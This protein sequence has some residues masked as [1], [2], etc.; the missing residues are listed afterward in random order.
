MNRLAAWALRSPFL[1]GPAHLDRCMAMVLVGLLLWIPGAQAQVLKDITTDI[2]A[3][4]KGPEAMNPAM[5]APG[6]P[7][8]VPAAQ[9]DEGRLQPGDF[10]FIEVQRYPHLSVSSTLDAAGQVVIPHLGPVQLAGLDEQGAGAKVKEALSRILRTPP[11]VTVSRSASSLMGPQRSAEMRTELIPLQNADADEMSQALQGMTS[12]GGNI[13]Y[14]PGTHML[15]IT[16]T[17]D[18][19]RNIMSVVSRLDERRSRMTQV[20]IEARIAEVRVGAMKEMGVRWFFQ[21]RDVLGGYLPLGPQTLRSRSLRG[22]QADPIN[23][24][25]VGGGGTGGTSGGRAYTEEGLFD[26]RLSMPVNIPK[27]GQLFL[28]VLTGAI[29]MGVMLDAL[30]AEDDAQLLAAPNILTVN[31]KP[32]LIESLEQFPVSTSMSTFAGTASGVSYVD[33]GIR[34]EVVPHVRKDD[35]G[36]Y[37]NI[38]LMPEVSYLV[39]TANGAPVR[40][41]R[42]SEQNANVRDGQT[43]VLGGIYRNDRKMLEQ[44][45]PGLKEVPLVGSLFKHVE[46]VEDQ[47]E[48]VVFVTPSIHTTPDSVTWERMLDVPTARQV[49]DEAPVV[50]SSLQ[51]RRKE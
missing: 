31:H 28:G 50:T 41:I 20:R 25:W 8:A 19:V 21:S 46:R 12:A 42:R 27:T 7:G 51:E 9:A 47:T 16:D 10:V 34:L 40:S 30:V 5:A 29:D 23:N 49:L 17:P 43:L 35:T 48:L 14:D 1:P 24:E 32:A 39:G 4:P 44:G 11:Q 45:V 13:S 37:V 18:T 15:I 22:S 26:R 2:G 33:I 6:L 38:Q 36:P 3:S